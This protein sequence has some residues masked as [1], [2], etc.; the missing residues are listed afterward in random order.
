VL[1]SLWFWIAIVLIAVGVTLT[2]ALDV[3]YWLVAAL[4]AAVLLI[5]GVFL[6]A[7]YAVGRAES[8][9]LPRLRE[10]PDEERVPLIYDC[11]VT[12]GQPFRDVGDGLALLYL[13]GEPRIDLQAITTTYG[14]GPR[15]MTTRTAR[16]LLS[17]LGLS[18]ITVAPGASGPADDPEEN[19]AARYLVDTVNARP[20]EIVLLA[21][22]AMTNLKHALTLDPDFFD[23]L[24]S[25][26]LVG[27]I[28][29]QLTW[30]GRLL[31][32][33]NF[34]LDPEAA[35]AA[36]QAACPTTITLGEAGLTAIF[37]SAQFAALQAMDGPISELVTQKTRFWFALMRLWFRDDGFASWESVAA[38][39]MAHPELFD[40]ER[41][42][43][44]ITVEDLRTGR[45]TVDPDRAGP[46]R[47]VRGVRDYEGFVQTQFAAWEHLDRLVSSDRKGPP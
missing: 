40:F 29:Q 6:Y 30:N 10:V 7:A 13:L 9:A 44:P 34:S 23:K 2:L 33:R 1:R 41:A 31:R 38:L 25:L 27:G 45:L 14:N 5:A 22:G 3:F 20:N 8:P 17:Q 18:G 4:V 37:R 46:V 11:D 21:T 47:L 28:T 16:R 26:Y 15:W 32:E 24:S 35:Y 19:E 42:H 43:L 12:I 36:L 39:S